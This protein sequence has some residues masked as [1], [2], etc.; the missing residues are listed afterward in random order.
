MNNGILFAMPD[1]DRKNLQ[2]LK[3]VDETAQYGAR[4]YRGQIVRISHI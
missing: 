1:Q 3:K 2:W 4:C